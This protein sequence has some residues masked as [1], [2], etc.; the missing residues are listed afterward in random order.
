MPSKQQTPPRVFERTRMAPGNATAAPRP[1]TIMIVEDEPLL[2]RFLSAALDDAGYEV[3]QASSAEGAV[4][5]FDAGKHEIELLLC[6]VGLPG[7]SGAS[8]VAR[9]SEQRP[10]LP[11]LL[12]SAWEKATLVQ[13]GLLRE[14][15]ELLQKP[16]G[17]DTLL[18]EVRARLG[19]DPDGR[20]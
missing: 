15:A 1:R 19:D 8:L 10:S 3:V 5:I 13:R 16:F 18:R 12:M 20:H 7:E 9:I 11:Y 6:D 14:D 2:R 4:Q 17:V